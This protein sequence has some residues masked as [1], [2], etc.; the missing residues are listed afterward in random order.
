MENYIEQHEYRGFNINIHHDDQAGNPRQEFDGMGHMVCFHSKYDLGDKHE[1]D[2]AEDLMEYLNEVH[3]EW[4]PLHLY[5]HSGITM[6]TSG[7]SCPWDSGQVG[8]IYMTIEEIEDEYPLKNYP[9]QIERA[10]K[11]MTGEVKEYDD[12]LTGS[13]YGY[14]IEPKDENKGIE[15]G[16][17]CWGYYGYDSISYMVDE[18]K[19]N[20]NY[21]IKEYKAQ[22]IVERD[23]KREI[24]KFMRSCWAY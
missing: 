15:C 5:D 16:D 23:R 20:I 8:V 13:V 11:Y 21:A 10:R 22:V 14:T 2:S 6:N 19:G 12:Y 7:F 4:L 1:F 18:A 3:A 24:N 9:D 17:S